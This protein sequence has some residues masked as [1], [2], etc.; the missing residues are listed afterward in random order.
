M[1]ILRSHK[2]QALRNYYKEVRA[3]LDP[4]E[5]AKMDEQIMLQLLK[6]NLQTRGY[7]YAMSYLPIKLS[8]EASTDRINHYLFHH[9]KP[10][11]QIA[12][13]RTD[14]NTLN[15]EAVLPDATTRYNQK[16][17]KLTEPES[18]EVLDPQKL[19]LIIM[20][21]LT[22]DVKGNRVGYGKGFYDR[23]L[24]RCRPGVLKVGLSYLP[25]INQIED[26]DKFDIPLD[27]CA[28]PERLY[29]FT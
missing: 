5:M 19:D 26:V 23:Y 21:L 24:A 20:P 29:D 3:A 18:G 27:Y 22:F 6:L 4:L 11:I 10:A 14:F 15:M 1:P 8:A 7:R 12:Y 28:T 16:W 13:P 17:L 25:A 2:K 9:V